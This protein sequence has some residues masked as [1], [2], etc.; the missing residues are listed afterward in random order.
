MPQFLPNNLARNWV[1]GPVFVQTRHIIP[2]VIN[3]ILDQDPVLLPDTIFIYFTPNGPECLTNC[4]PKSLQVNQQKGG[5]RKT[6]R[7]QS[8]L[9]A[10]KL[11]RKKT[12][13]KIASPP[14]KKT[15]KQKKKG[16]KNV[17]LGERN[18]TKTT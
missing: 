13:K 6:N 4:Q 3:F 16:E 18:R 17:K 15:Q 9:P 12:K 14:L 11:W 7:S 8:D 2:E 1:K 10:R 5:H